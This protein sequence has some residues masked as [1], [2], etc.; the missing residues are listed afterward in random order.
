MGG[1]HHGVLLRERV[2]GDEA[3]D[4]EVRDLHGTRGLR[5]RGGRSRE[6]DVGGLDVP[7]YYAV[8][9]SS[10]QAAGDA[11]RD[12]GGGARWEG[13]FLFQ[14]VGECDARHVLHNDV[15][16]AVL[17]V[18]AE[19]VDGDDVRVGER[20]GAA[21]LLSEAFEHP[22]VVGEAAAQHLQRDLPAQ[23]L[24]AGQEDLAEAPAAERPQDGVAIIHPSYAQRSRN[25]PLLLLGRGERRSAPVPRIR[26]NGSLT[27]AQGSPH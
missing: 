25:A 14:N 9:V 5:I 17:G 15:R 19:V 7:V 22:P 6:K 3:G 8:P 16:G 10:L 11:Q 20:G 24:V 18:L 27:E 23:D 4:A 12:G 13:A 21:R 2:L 26:S 1:A